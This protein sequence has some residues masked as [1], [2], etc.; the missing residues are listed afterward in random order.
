MLKPYKKLRAF[1]GR[2]ILLSPVIERQGRVS[3]H[4]Q[5]RARC[6]TVNPWRRR[7]PCRRRFRPCDWKIPEWC[8]LF[9]ETYLAERHAAT[10]AV[11][12]KTHNKE[13]SGLGIRHS[14]QEW[15]APA[16]EKRTAAGNLKSYKK[17][18]RSSGDFVTYGSN[19][20]HNQ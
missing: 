3:S 16:Q 1:S 17:A 7:A 19:W 13:G 10:K 20:R 8:A 14:D 15:I 9:N 4:H 12:D 5:S 2:A 6:T 11:I 18:L